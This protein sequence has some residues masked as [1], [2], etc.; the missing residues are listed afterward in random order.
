MESETV[1]VEVLVKGLALYKLMRMPIRYSNVLSKSDI[2]HPTL[3]TWRALPL[4]GNS[5][6]DTPQVVSQAD[7][8]VQASPLSIQLFDHRY[9][10]L[11]VITIAW[12]VG[13]VFV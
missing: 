2:V 1:D 7:W 10:Q 12:I 5:P 13:V 6:Q 11:M 8:T 3:Q 9:R 4:S